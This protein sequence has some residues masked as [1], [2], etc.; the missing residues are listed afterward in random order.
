MS[1][2]KYITKKNGVILCGAMIALLS[3]FYLT[4]N[5]RINNTYVLKGKSPVITIHPVYPANY[6]DD[7]ILVGASHNV[8]IGKVVGRLGVQTTAVGPITQF[9]VQ[10]ISNIK[11]ALKGIVTVEQE[12]G[13]ENGTL[14]VME[15]SDM[16]GTTNGGSV[17]YFL[18]Q[19]ST[20]LLATRY[21]P[22]SD[23]YMLGPFSVA[24]A[25]VSANDNLDNVQLQAIAQS[26]RRVEQLQAAYPHE[27]LL[28]ADV[29]HDNTRNSYQSLP[30]AQALTSSTT[31]TSTQSR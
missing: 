21:D 31:T 22:D 25:L 16:L 4:S 17:G 2:Q 20:Y 29:A 23:S 12:G 3:V 1:M 9:S 7:R 28:H 18:Q 30:A 11:G 13:Y 27:I 14:Y 19:G 15:D 5:I 10:I 24:S 6:A 26:N 8:F